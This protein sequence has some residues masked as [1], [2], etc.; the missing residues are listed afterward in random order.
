MEKNPSEAGEIIVDN[1]GY[2]TVERWNS[3]YRVIYEF[4]GPPIM[5]FPVN[6]RTR[7]FQVVQD[8]PLTQ[9]AWGV[10]AEWRRA[11]FLARGA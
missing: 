10:N 9:R 4:W 11:K 7:K 8:F 2:G 5:S 1:G 3:L 6:Q